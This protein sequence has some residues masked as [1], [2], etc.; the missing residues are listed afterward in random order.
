M[1]IT[2]AGM[3]PLKQYFLGQEPP[4]AP[5]LTS[6]QKC[7]RT[8]DIDEVGRTARHLTFFEMMG[9]FSI[10]D[11]FKDQAVE[12]AWEFVDL[13]RR[14]GVR[15]RQAVGDDLPRRRAGARRRGGRARCGAAAASPPSGSCGWAAITSGR[16]ARS[17]PC[18][19]CSELYYDRGAEYGCDRADCAPGCDCD[20][21]LEFWN[22]V[23]MQYNMLDGGG[24][25]PLPR[26]SIDTGCGV[27]RT[28]MLSEGVDSVYD[29]DGFRDVI[30]DRRG[31]GRRALRPH[32]AGDQGAAGAR[33]PRPGDDF[34]A[35]DGIEPGNEGRG[36][37]LRRVI[38]R[39]MLQAGRIG[40]EGE[41]LP[42]LHARV[43]ELLGDVYPELIAGE[44]TVSALLRAEE[45]RFAR[46][47]ETGAKLLDE[48]LADRAERCRPRTPS[49]CTTPTGSRSS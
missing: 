32:A 49:G 15:P 43:V 18:G 41:F 22:L 1:L 33:R 45:Q 7:F 6:V 47:L 46:T 34:L 26:P 28:T 3:Q 42:R 44:A 8:V 12:W 48:V 35:T 19:P 13:A 29:T 2:T 36:Y 4:P 17:G 38:R 40:I 25:E 37:V 20:R 31:L 39:A 24:L 21:F 27:E 16:P 23:F 5:R 9:N 30:D 14:T 10:G 11:Y